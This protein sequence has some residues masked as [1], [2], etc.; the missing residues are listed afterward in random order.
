MENDKIKYLDFRAEEPLYEQLTHILIN[1]IAL[2][3]YQIDDQ[4]LTER[5]I[6]ERF[7]VS[8]IT[9]KSAINELVHNNLLYRR[10]RKGTFIKNNKIFNNQQLNKSSSINNIIFVSPMLIQ[11][12]ASNQFYSKIHEVIGKEITGNRFH[13]EF[14]ILDNGKKK[15]KAFLT[16]IKNGK[17]KG[18]FF[19]GE[20]LNKSLILKI[21]NKG[22]YIETIEGVRD[23]IKDKN[24]FLKII[25]DKGSASVYETIIK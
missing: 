4:F 23:K 15:N 9:A 3:K 10:P 17:L 1:E 18:I 21:R 12:A 19:L 6:Q 22:I 20:A 14:F 2:N 24:I 7:K 16:K 11:D 8:R 13:F 5:D 25:D